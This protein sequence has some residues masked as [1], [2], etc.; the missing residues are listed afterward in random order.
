VSH[1]G[2]LDRPQGIGQFLNFFRLP[3][4]GDDLQ[5]VVVI[6]MDVLGGDDRLLERVISVG[7]PAHDVP[8]MV[9]VDE[10]DG[11]R[12]IPPVLP[13]P[14]DQFPANQVPQGL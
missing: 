5:A 2:P 3:A 7:Y 6:E 11:A 12:Y 13:F 1:D 10:G 4:G 9:V 14:L 8:L